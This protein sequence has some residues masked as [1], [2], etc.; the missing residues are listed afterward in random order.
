MQLVSVIIPYYKK[1]KYISQTIKSILNQSYSK[2][3]IILIHDDPG[4]NDLRN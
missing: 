4:N 1:S 3:E 2:I